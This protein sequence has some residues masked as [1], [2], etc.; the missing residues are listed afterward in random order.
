[1][2]ANVK[3]TV[4]DRARQ[5][6]EPLIAAEG[7]ELVDVEYKREHAGWILRLFI[8]K[9]G[10]IGIEDCTR[11]SHAVET[12]LDVEDFIPQEYQLEV[13][14]PGL[15]RPLTKP[16]HYESAAGKLVRVKTFGPIGTPPRKNFLGTLKGVAPERIIVSVE[17]AGDFEIPF[18]DIAA[19]NLE[20]EFSK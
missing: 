2:T 17:G 4:E 19:A 12:A 16:R 11:A 7:M 5:V 14:S 8:D 20:F 13:S 1:M 6:A 9:P 3:H 15:N 10:G 18:K